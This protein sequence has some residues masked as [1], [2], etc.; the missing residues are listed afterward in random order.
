[1]EKI[2]KY[3]VYT[4]LD[5]VIPLTIE[6]HYEIDDFVLDLA[7]RRCLKASNGKYYFFDSIRMVEYCD[8]T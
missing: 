6:S 5:L 7:M 8:E 3:Y 4:T 1:M 2:Y